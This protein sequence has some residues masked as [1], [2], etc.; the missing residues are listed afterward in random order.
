M[1]VGDNQDYN[2]EVGA[3]SMKKRTTLIVRIDAELAGAIADLFKEAVEASDYP[4]KK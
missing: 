3:A 1:Y 4:L 2:R